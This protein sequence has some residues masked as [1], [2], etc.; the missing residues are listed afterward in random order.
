MKN[1]LLVLSSLIVAIAACVGADRLVGMFRPAQAETAGLIFPTNVE[2]RFRTH[3]F[4]YRVRTNSLGFRDREFAVKKTAKVRILAIG[5]S[6]TFGFGVE[7]NQAWPKVLEAR[8]RAAGED[9]EIANLGRP[10]SSPRGYA[11]VAE[12]AIPVLKPDF[13]IVAMLQGDDLGQLALPPGGDSQ[14]EVRWTNNAGTEYPRLRRVMAPLFPH[15]LALADAMQEPEMYFRWQRDARELLAH[16]SPVHKARFEKLDA[17]VRQA[18]VDGELNPALVLL[19]I[20]RPDYFL[21]T[22]NVDSPETRHLTDEMAHQLSR[23]E[24]AARASGAAVVVVSVPY[25][26]Y[27]SR[28]SFQ[29]RQQLGFE[30]VPEML[31]TNAADEAVR[32]ASAIAGLPFHQVTEAFRQASLQRDLFFELDGHF[33]AAGHARFAELLAPEIEKMISKPVANERAGR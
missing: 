13:V 6:F 10:G 22:M 25:G 12:K 11:A 28:S 14:A 2:H 20:S 9:V 19:S 23:I 8:L 32:R 31:T 1:V 33:N 3:E 21:S 29:T 24:T 17:R 16:M 18:F 4:S 27:V 30:A 7:G 26:I 5:D 15:L